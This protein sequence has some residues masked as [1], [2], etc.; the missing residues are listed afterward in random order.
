MRHGKATPVHVLSWRENGDS[1]DVAVTANRLAA[2]GG[3]VR[4]CIETRDGIEAGDYLAAIPPETAETLSDLGLT[5]RRL[6]REAPAGGPVA[7]VR[8]AV[9]A[10]AASAY[11]YYGYYALALARLGYD[12]EV[13]D[14]AA[15]AAGALDAAD[16]LALPG[17]FSNWGL[18]AK[19]KTSGA[20]SAVRRFLLTG[21]AAIG[22]CGGAYYL[23]SGR[24]GWLGL[25]AARPRFTQ[26]YLRSGAGVVTCSLD[27]PRLGL[28]LP[29]DLDLV[30]YHGPIYDTL[31]PGTS[32]LGTFARFDGSARLFIDNPLQEATFEREMRGRT[33]VVAAEGERG[34][35]IL[36]SAHPEMGDLLR[37]YMALEDYIPR[38][39]P[40]RGR[41]VMEETLRYYRPEESRS[42]CL[43]L[44]A[45][46]MLSGAG[47]RGVEREPPP[48]LQSVD[49]S[50]LESLSEAWQARRARLKASQGGLGEL[51]RMVADDL[52][53]RFAAAAHRL[54][55]RLEGLA[56]PGASE[57]IGRSFAAVAGHATT[58]LSS[59]PDLRRPAETLL[60]LELAVLLLEA[61]LRLADID[62]SVA[63][64]VRPTT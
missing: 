51:E 38:Y 12:I 59:S 27:H 39:L 8:I 40:V 4:R 31:G 15:I 41:L 64:H 62:L 18:D 33:A 43:L 11:P 7:S 45:V 48:A 58:A 6:D 44:N 52:A 56:R 55:S 5:A 19:E 57:S 3:G 22:S 47:R 28:G 2:H 36:F 17:G 53:E 37:K 50:A 46:E 13:V 24:P 30:Y 25:A 29:P 26:E 35:A 61:W 34:R 60:E 42:F 1:L 23:S 14:G 49:T 63:E 16:L 54:P 20:D 21:G 32:A 10:G 9:L